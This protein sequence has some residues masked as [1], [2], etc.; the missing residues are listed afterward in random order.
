LIS[1]LSRRPPATTRAQAKMVG[2][3]Y[4]YRHDRA[5]ALGFTP[6]PARQALAE[7]V[8][9]LAASPHISRQLRSTLRL[10][11]EVYEARR[12]MEEREAAIKGDRGGDRG[13]NRGG[14]E[15]A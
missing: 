10:A 15:R 5:A 2:R 4:W 9:W 13:A 1:W 11:P 3:Y 14:N 12:R 7:A 8:A 6:E